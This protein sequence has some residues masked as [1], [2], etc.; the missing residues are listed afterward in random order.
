MSGVEVIGLVLGGLPLI[1]SIGEHYK[2]G[3]EPLARWKRFRL[4]FREFITA[5]DTQ[6][7]MFRLVLINLLAP[8]QLEPEE[9]QRLLTVANYEGWHRS[10]VVE[11]LKSRLGNAYDACM[12]ILRTMNEDM[13][14]LQ[15]MMSLKNGTVDWA[16]SGKNQWKYQLKRIEFSFSENGTRTVQSL[17]KK[18]KDLERL[19]R[20]LDGTNDTFEGTKTVLKGTSWGELFENIRRHAV[21]L[22]SVIKN[23]WNCN[24]EMSHL[25][26]LQLQKRQASDCPPRFIINLALPQR[27]PTSA[28]S[29]RKLLIYAKDSRDTPTPEG[30]QPVLVEETHIP[31]LRTHF[32]PKSPPDVSSPTLL[33]WPGLRSSSSSV[34]S[35]FSLRSIFPKS[36]ILDGTGN[37]ALTLSSKLRSMQKF[38]SKK[39]LRFVPDLPTEPR[40]A[41]GAKHCLD[42]SQQ[43]CLVTPPPPPPPP[44]LAKDKPRVNIKIKDLCSAMKCL[45]PNVEFFGCLSDNEHQEHEVRW[46]K[47]TRQAP[48]SLGEISLE[49]LLT[50]NGHLKLSRQK[51]YKLASIVASSLLQLHA[52]PWLTEKLE[53]KNIFFY[54]QGPNILAEEPYISHKFVASKPG[55]SVPQ[56]PNTTWVLPIDP[57]QTLRC[58]GMLLLELCF[59]EAI[60]NQQS[61]RKAH[62]SSDGKAL[63]GTDYLCALAWVEMVEEEEPKIEPIIRWCISCPLNGTLNWEDTTFTQKV[64]GF[65]VKPLEMLVVPT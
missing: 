19:L 25:A 22:H 37:L 16:V 24:C 54:H 6:K 12:D 64:Y 44:P 10:D 50:S 14:D 53:K 59:G 43:S 60:E 32:Q 41:E 31:Q 17:E 3:F 49:K 45:D 34:S 65:V 26:N 61:L 42:D 2:K 4:V 13:V 47:D 5:V 35:S 57:R 52:T 55:D 1:I 27:E 9:K 46:I 56:E 7:Q 48:P 30:T 58:L 15:A 36:E 18:I 29:R 11:A 28:N 38:K 39:T 40:N 33:V 51:R 23:S 8:V 21:T 20:L 62:L 63:D